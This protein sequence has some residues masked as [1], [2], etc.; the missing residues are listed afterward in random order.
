MAR[1]HNA[2]A[3]AVERSGSAVQPRPKLVE[4]AERER[5]HG[6][7]IVGIDRQRLAIVLDRLAVSLACVAA[8]QIMAALELLPGLAGGGAAPPQLRL[9]TLGEGKLQARD[10]LLRHLVLE[11]EAASRVAV[12]ALHPQRETIPA[13]H[14]PRHDAHVRTA[15]L[16]APREHV[17]VRQV[18]RGVAVVT[19]IELAMRERMSCTSSTSASAR[20]PALPGFAGVRNGSSLSTG[21]RSCCRSRGGVR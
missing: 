15:A 5:H 6:A 14:E 16:N 9:L 12:I 21:L 13:G 1:L 10:D 17:V 18:V 20:R 7:E 11:I 19:E 4:L 2:S 3:S 8:F